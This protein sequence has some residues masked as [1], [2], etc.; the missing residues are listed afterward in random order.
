MITFAYKRSE[1]TQ[2][3]SISVTSWYKC[4]SRGFHILILTHCLH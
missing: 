2:A 4:N 1:Y 3:L